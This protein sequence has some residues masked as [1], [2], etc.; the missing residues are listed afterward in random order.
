MS[1]KETE[2]IVSTVRAFTSKQIAVMIALIGGVVSG[3]VFIEDRYAKNIVT[4]ASIE[5]TQGEITD[6]TKEMKK[7]LVDLS[8]LTGQ[9][10]VLMNSNSGKSVALTI[11]PAVAPVLT[12][13]LL[14][15]IQADAPKIPA[16]EQAVTT[17]NNLIAK[18]A[19]IVKR[20]RD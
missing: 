14:A 8:I 12:P 6:L 19:D 15:K 10:I 2:E 5:K 4:R 3:V 11:V 20:S 9:M 16:N 13:E 18:Q 7:Q 17:Q 1:I